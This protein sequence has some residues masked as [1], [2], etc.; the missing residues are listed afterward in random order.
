MKNLNHKRQP[1]LLACAA[2]PTG[3]RVSVFH[4]E[5]EL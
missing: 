3:T 2:G 4:N 5:K 1:L